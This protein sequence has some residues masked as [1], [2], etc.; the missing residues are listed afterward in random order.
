MDFIFD[1]IGDKIVD[2]LELKELY[3]VFPMTILSIAFVMRFID[4]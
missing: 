4:P 1:S 3:L 2:E